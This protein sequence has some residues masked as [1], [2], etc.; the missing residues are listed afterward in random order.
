M[1]LEESGSRTVNPDDVRDRANH[2]AMDEN[3]PQF[4]AE[5]KALKKR[6]NGMAHRH[7][8]LDPSI[9]Q[10]ITNLEERFMADGGESYR[11]M[12][13]R[14]EAR[15]APKPVRRERTPTNIVP[16]DEIGSGARQD[17]FIVNSQRNA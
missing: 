3:H 6:A 1:S 10:A 8:D 15:R 2:I 12:M 4:Q 16:G 5:A 17:Y 14:K 9:E 7:A 13:A 11:Q